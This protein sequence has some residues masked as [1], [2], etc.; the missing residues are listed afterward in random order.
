MEDP[1]KML[2]K[3][4]LFIDKNRNKAEEGMDFGHK[5]AKAWHKL[6]STIL[7]P[8]KKPL[9]CLMGKIS[10]RNKYEKYLLLLSSKTKKK[11]S[12]RKGS[13]SEKRSGSKSTLGAS[14]SVLN[15]PVVQVGESHSIQI[16]DFLQLRRA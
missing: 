7:S 11:F 1:A 9:K 15:E 5:E 12:L 13:S 16:K 8:S 10:E 4:K 3:I 2:E 14:T 6:A